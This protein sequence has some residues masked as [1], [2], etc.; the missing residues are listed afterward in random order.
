MTHLHNNSHSLVF[1]SGL[2]GTYTR[3]FAF[4][5]ETFP[6]KTLKFHFKRYDYKVLFVLFNHG[7]VVGFTPRVDWDK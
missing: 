1:T 5:F 6:A 4:S 2:H 3:F 7:F